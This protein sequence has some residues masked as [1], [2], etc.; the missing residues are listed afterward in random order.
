[1]HRED[2]NVV[3]SVPQG[4]VV[5]HLLL[6]FYTSDLS[7]I[8]KNTLGGNADDATF[9]VEV[10]KLGNRVSTVSSL[11]RDLDRIRV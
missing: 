1:M 7:T 8:F 6:T 3:S 10:P 9:L 4:G 5:G 2:L 11:N